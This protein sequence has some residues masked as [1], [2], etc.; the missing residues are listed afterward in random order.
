MS[1]LKLDEIKMKYK[2]Y[3][4]L[5]S[6][7]EPKIYFLG[8]AIDEL[9]KIG[10]VTNKSAIYETKAWGNE[11]QNDF[12]NSVIRFHTDL[13]PLQLLS[14]IKSAEKKIGRESETEKWGPR[15]IDIDILF[16]DNINID[17][18][19]LTIPHKYFSERNFVLIP[20]MELNHKYKP[21][22]NENDIAFY[23]NHSNDNNYV[24]LSI[25]NW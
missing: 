2:Y 24:N 23:F 8:K 20:M 5:G 16:A 18:D 14:N 4:G 17:N 9:K 15:I 21:E 11:Q 10:E 6:N 19:D 13:D 7:I 25:E 12:I 3:L 1:K 22:N